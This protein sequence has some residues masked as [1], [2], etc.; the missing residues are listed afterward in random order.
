MSIEFAQIVLAAATQQAQAEKDTHTEGDKH[1]VLIY[2]RHGV[3]LFGETVR[4][5]SFWE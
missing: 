3:N 1:I 5:S 4:I 2:F